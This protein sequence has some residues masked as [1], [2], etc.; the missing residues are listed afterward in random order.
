[1]S[2][3][4]ALNKTTT[5]QL[6]KIFQ[7]YEQVKEVVMYGSRAK[8]THNERSDIDLAI[9]NSNI[10]RH[11]LGKIKLQIDNSNI[12]YLVD[13]QIVEKIK[14]PSL[15]EHIQSIGKVIYKANC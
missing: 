14:N 15:L 1:M 4:S 10:N 6:S 8:G 7:S 3:L 2:K 9:R 11:T 13:L 5:E 12:P